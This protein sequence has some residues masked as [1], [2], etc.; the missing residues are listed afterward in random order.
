MS[1]FEG[2][3]QICCWPAHEWT[4]LGPGVRASLGPW[5]RWL[6]TVSEYGGLVLPEVLSGTHSRE[7]AEDGAAD[8]TRLMDV[9]IQNIQHV[10]VYF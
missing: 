5:F 7:G 9:G 3:L 8:T 10:N 6:G 4:G 2:D 1:G